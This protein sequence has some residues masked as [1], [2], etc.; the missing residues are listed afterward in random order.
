MAVSVTE[1]F[2]LDYELYI[3]RVMELGKT[4]GLNLFEVYEDSRDIFDDVFF[5]HKLDLG[6]DLGLGLGFGLGPNQNQDQDQ[7]QNEQ[8]CK[9][10]EIVATYKYLCYDQKS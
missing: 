8:L 7:D 9:R 1:N 4:S 10:Y 2:D 3:Q 5:K 6:L